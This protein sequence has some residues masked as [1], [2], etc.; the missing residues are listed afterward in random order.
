MKVIV[1]GSRTITDIAIV[2][3]AL[4]VADLFGIDTTEVVSG[5]AQ[6]VDALGEAW[7]NR[8]GLPVTQ[9]PA[10]WRAGGVFNPGAGH[11][12]NTE[13]SKYADAL[14]AV[15]DGTSAGTADMIKKAHKRGLA[16][17]VHNVVN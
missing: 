2:A 5:G 1:A 16:V 9:F 8:R 4:S 7:A 3:E 17:W 11:A 13:M 15:W 10:H 6:G 14:V 12:R